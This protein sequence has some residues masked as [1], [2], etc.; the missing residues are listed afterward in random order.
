MRAATSPR[1]V[2]QEQKSVAAEADFSK[3]RAVAEEP[4][5]PRADCGGNEKIGKSEQKEASAS[6]A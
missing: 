3:Q 5:F 6:A 4:D 2:G 1:I